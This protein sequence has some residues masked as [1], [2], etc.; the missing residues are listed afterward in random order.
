[1]LKTCAGLAK[2]GFGTSHLC[3]GYIGVKPRFND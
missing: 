1:M 2:S 3:V